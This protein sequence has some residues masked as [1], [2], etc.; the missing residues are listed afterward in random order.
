MSNGPRSFDLVISGGRVIDPGQG[1]DGRFEV[2]VKGDR[3][4]AVAP[5]L[6]AYE[7]KCVVNAN[8]KLVCAGLIDLH[9]HVYEWATAFGLPADDAGINAGVTTGVDVG[10]SA[11]W[12]FPGF[13]A[14]VIDRA[15]TEIVA[16][17]SITLLGPMPAHRGGPQIFSVDFVDVDALCAMAARFPTLIRGIKTYAE[18][19][20]WSQ[21]GKR[22]LT[23]AV[24]AGNRAGL[25]L[26]I[27]TGELLQVDEANRPLAETVLPEVLELARPGDILGHCYSNK[28]DGILGNRNEPLPAL[29]EAVR[30]GVRLDVGHGINFS[31]ETARRMI[32]AGLLPYSISSDVHCDLIGEHDETTLNYSLVGTMSKLLALGIDLETIIAGTTLHPARILGKADEIGTLMP[33]SRADISILE[34]VEGPWTFR[35]SDNETLNVDRRFVPAVVV[36][37]GRA[38]L[39]SC[40]LLKDVLPA[41]SAG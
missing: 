33:G 24:D 35:D 16:F 34:L 36:R 12:N 18:S 6:G 20:A 31:F 2:A 26:Y 21:S 39:P 3:I 30:N 15:E 4:A 19:G 25:P 29:V 10:S 17:P 14:Q 41:V 22:F 32:D 7:A 8:G 1:L 9:V 5:N 23:L 13:K 27:H 37:D 40:R 28:S 11:T 38:I